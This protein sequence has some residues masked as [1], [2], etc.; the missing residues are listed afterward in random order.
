MKRTLSVVF[1]ATLAASTV[2]VVAQEGML[3]TPQ[4]RSSQEAIRHAVSTATHNAAQPGHL[5]SQ[6]VA[7]SGAETNRSWDALVGTV[8][9][10][11]KVIVTL[12]NATSVEGKL[13]AIDMRS[14]S[15]DQ[16][17]GPRAIEAADVVR[18]RYAGVRKRHVIYGM[19]IGM[20]GGAVANVIIDKQSSHPSS[21]A[22]AAGLGAIFVGL[23]IG[24]AGGALVPIGQPLYEAAHGVRETP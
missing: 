22:E 15:V 16:R 20:A 9:T 10:G 3:V 4:P 23:P 21:T 19:L 11:R 7:A 24:A 18:V 12:V 5:M 13:L 1:V 14:I 8:K 2:A 17:E 6:S